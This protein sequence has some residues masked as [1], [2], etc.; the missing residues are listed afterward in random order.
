MN[1][2]TVNPALCA[3]VHTVA[4]GET[5]YGI[6][7]SFGTDFRRLMKLNGIT[8]PDRLDVGQ[9]ICIPKMP[10]H[11][12]S[13]PGVPQR[14]FHIVK[15]GETLYGIARMYGV[16]LSKLM[17]CN[18]ALDPYHLQIGTR[19]VIPAAAPAA[20]RPRT[21][22][23][24][25]EASASLPKGEDAPPLDVPETD[26]SAEEA[27]PQMPV[28]VPAEA[29]GV[30]RP[31]AGR[32][33]HTVT[34]EDTLTSILTRYAI[35][36]HALLQ[37]NPHAGLIESLNPKTGILLQIPSEDIYHRCARNQ[38]YTVKSGDTLQTIAEEHELTTHELLR[39]NPCCCP[40]DFSIAG[41]RIR[42]PDAL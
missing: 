33:L 41:T 24:T 37:E 2:E 9:K 18:P 10:E 26:T 29:A 8:D 42:V 5:L 30:S 31:A 35:C 23:E 25:A 27:L 28:S 3:A 22:A 14:R 11:R 39:L 1:Y 32:I 15:A 38:P 13:A 40:L 21:E 17:A 20:P 34:E 4:P 36:F 16:P 19:L 7:Q 6:A 12:P